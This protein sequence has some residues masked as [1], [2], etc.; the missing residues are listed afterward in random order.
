MVHRETF[1]NKIRSIGYAFKTETKRAYLWRK[2]GSTHFI[3]VP[4]TEIL[5]DD[6]VK[7]SLWQAGCT[8]EEIEGF[9]SSAKS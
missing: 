7:S 3:Y 9:V 5:E 4:K 2:K 6:F 1:I 8:K